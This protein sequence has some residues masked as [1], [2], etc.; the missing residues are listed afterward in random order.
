MFVSR[1]PESKIVWV[2]P[3]EVESLLVDLDADANFWFV[4]WYEGVTRWNQA[5]WA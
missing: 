2:N 1:I 5:D 4:Y 3:M